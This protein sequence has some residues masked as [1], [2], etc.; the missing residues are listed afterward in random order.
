MAKKINLDT[1][2]VVIAAIVIAVAASKRK[3]APAQTPG[4]SAFQSGRY[5]H[6]EAVQ[7][8]TDNYNIS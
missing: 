1:K 8:R 7:Q 6:G 2:T 3:P 4:P 5:G